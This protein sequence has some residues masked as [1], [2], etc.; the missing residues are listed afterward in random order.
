MEDNRG[1]LKEGEVHPSAQSALDY[2]KG[3]GP[4]KLCMYLEAFASCSIEGNRLGEICSETLNRIM[5]G[6]GISDRYA[7]GLAWTL[8][9]MEEDYESRELVEEEA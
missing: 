2:I 7:L 3:L 1:T 6:K 9:N 5:T 4:Q 8:R